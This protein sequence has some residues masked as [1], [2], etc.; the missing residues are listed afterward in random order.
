M[1]KKLY[2]I[3]IAIMQS[4]LVGLGVLNLSYLDYTEQTIGNSFL[5]YCMIA[6]SGV[7][8][9]ADLMYMIIDYKK[10]YIQ[11]IAHH[12]LYLVLAVLS[13]SNTS[14]RFMRYIFG[15]VLISEASGII[16]DIEAI[17]KL[18][19]NPDADPL[20][21]TDTKSSFLVYTK[22]VFLV[23]FLLIRYILIPYLIIQIAQQPWT[24]YEY[25]VFGINTVA[26]VAMHAFWLYKIIG[27]ALRKFKKKPV[28]SN[29]PDV[30]SKPDT[31]K[32][33]DIVIT[34]EKKAELEDQTRQTA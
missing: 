2:F 9:I 31:V 6:L 26:Y 22:V 30:K 12:I 34:V 21:Y 15:T 5:L 28:I 25:S 3:S 16:L 1:S 7:F 11:Y 27:Y 4:L 14:F 33:D 17:Y 32:D 13:V 23:V 10:Q 20:E 8:F 19:K 18:H 24:S 29:A